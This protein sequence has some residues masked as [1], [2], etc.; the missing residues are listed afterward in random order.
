MRNF[1][2]TLLGLILALLA[3]VVFGQTITADNFDPEVHVKVNAYVNKADLSE[4][5]DFSVMVVL[6]VPETYHI[7]KGD[8]FFVDGSS[9]D[10]NLSKPI[11]GE[12][13][14]WKGHGV[15]KGTVKVKLDGKFNPNADNEKTLIVAYQNCIETG[16]ESCFMPIEKEIKIDFTNVNS[17]VFENFKTG[18]VK[19]VEK[20]EK[21]E[22][23][24]KSDSKDY[25]EQL[26]EKIRVSDDASDA[27]KKAQANKLKW[28]WIIFLAA[29]LG[30]ILDSFTPCV[31]P[32]IPVVISYMGSKSGGKKKAGFFLS[33]FFVLGLA[34]TYSLVGLGAAFVGGQ[35]GVSSLAANPYVLGFVAT[36][37][38]LLS[39]SMFGVYD[40][41]LLSS[42]RQTK[43][44]QKNYTGVLGAVF[45]G[46]VSGVI[47][48][49]CVGPVLAALLI[50]VALVGD[51]LYGW[52]IFM[53]FAF[54]LGLLFIVIGT[55]SGA[56]NALPRAGTWMVSIKKF[57]GVIM[58]GAALFFIR[59]FLPDWLLNGLLAVLLT[60]LATYIGA[61]RKL[62]K[63]DGFF[64]HLGKALGIVIII[65]STVFTLKTL[66]EFVE[67]PFKTEVIGGTSIEKVVDE[68][69]F[70]KTHD[71][72]FVDD[73]AI[74]IAKAENKI[75]MIDFWAEWCMNCLELDKTTW[76]DPRVIEYS[77]NFIPIKLDFTKRSSDFSKKF[78]EKY[79]TRDIPVII[80]LDGDGNLIKRIT[81]YRD[82]DR[83]LE[84]M[85]EVYNKVHNN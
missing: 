85:K 23:S 14:D 56:I 15:Y 1:R 35:F 10:H 16:D 63:G 22:V 59:I 66:A 25:E 18:A 36:V 45:L 76:K 77:K 72:M 19:K 32:V 37:F 31:Y 38:F 48:A 64:I 3:S 81:G 33:L 7:T 83:M 4:G 65:V 58:I 34:F 21:A 46:A 39:L 11:Y 67:L 68:V 40:I 60:L 49:P 52:L 42:D 20:T 50:H 74:E 57:F 28:T 30:G 17:E 13:Q 12:E 61:F 71:D 5:D 24:E 9:I 53:T 69:A 6:D 29:F 8:Y 51:M 78:I 80:F 47:A 82:G 26:F 84:I 44:M 2:F 79:D 27:E 43:L 41:N 62:E 75:V 73:N 54:G 70:A 55:F